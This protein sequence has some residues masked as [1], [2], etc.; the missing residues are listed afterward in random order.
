MVLDNED[1]SEMESQVSYGL[2]T[3]KNGSNFGLQNQS[4]GGNIKGFSIFI[5]VYCHH[6]IAKTQMCIS[7]S[8]I[9]HEGERFETLHVCTAQVTDLLWVGQVGCIGVFSRSEED[10]L[11]EPSRKSS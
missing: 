3:E 4:I 5:T 11:Q 8:E 9:K 2:L 6:Q 7:Q 10:C 1:Q